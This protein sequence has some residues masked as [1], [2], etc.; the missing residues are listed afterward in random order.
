MATR[1]ALALGQ[2]ILWQ[3][4][5]SRIVDG[6]TRMH[7]KGRRVWEHQRVIH[8]LETNTRTVAT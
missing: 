1:S 5:A 2:P 4:P 7:L 6:S 8:F 3:C